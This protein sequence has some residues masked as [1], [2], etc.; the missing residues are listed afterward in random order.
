MSVRG[1]AEQGVT[2]ERRKWICRMGPGAA[3]AGTE[4]KQ[5]REEGGEL[6]NTTTTGFRKENQKR[7]K[8]AGGKV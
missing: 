2:G 3:D 1:P 4:A 7:R 6:T 5:C 8:G